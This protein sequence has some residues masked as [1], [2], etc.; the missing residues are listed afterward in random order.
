MSYT[1]D[2]SV[3]QD[4]YCNQTKL[5]LI[6]SSRQGHGPHVF[7]PSSSPGGADTARSQQ[8]VPESQT[9]QKDTSSIGRVT[10]GNLILN[11][12]WHVPHTIACGRQGT[13]DSLL[14][15]CNARC[16]CQLVTVVIVFFCFFCVFFNIKEAVQ[17]SHVLLRIVHCEDAPSCDLGAPLER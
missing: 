5:N 15:A 14:P 17:T 11:F 7:R 12:W 6:W 16:D 8:P 2:I 13:M 1:L 4:E 10:G 9:T 3:C